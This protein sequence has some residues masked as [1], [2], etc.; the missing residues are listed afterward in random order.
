MFSGHCFAANWQQGIP[1]RDQRCAIVDNFHHLQEHVPEE[2]D[3]AEIT[4]LER[5]LAKYQRNLSTQ[6]RRKGRQRIA[7][8]ERQEKTRSVTSRSSSSTS[9][10]DSSDWKKV[11][12]SA[13]LLGNCSLSG[14][15]C[16]FDDC[17]T[18]MFFIY[19][20]RSHKEMCYL[21]DFGIKFFD[22][23]Y[24]YFYYV[25]YFLI[26]LKYMMFY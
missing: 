6:R 17:Q 9:S 24:Y 25:Y 11:R 5:K 16:R 15:A 12:A 18:S 14:F 26:F 2:E 7:V 4:S 8:K 22:I 21:A 3:F 13:L 23:I 20:K 10:S 19:E 1:T